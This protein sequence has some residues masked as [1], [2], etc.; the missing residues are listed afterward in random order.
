MSN[1]KQIQKHHTS[2]KGP[3][4]VAILISFAAVSVLYFNFQMT[5][6]GADPTSVTATSGKVKTS[7]P[8][9]E[10]PRIAKRTADT[11]PRDVA[12]ATSDEIGNTSDG[13]VLKGRMAL[14]L[15]LLLLERGCNHFKHITHY[16]ATFFKQEELDGDL[17]EGQIIEMKVRHQPFS[18]YMKWL[19]GDK[20]QEVLFVDGHY[21][22]KM[23]VK[24]GGLKGRFL[25]ALKLDPTGS[26][27][28]R[29][30]RYPVTKAGLLQLARTIVSYREH[31]LKMPNGV[32]CQMVDNQKFSDRDT[33]YFLIEYAARENSKTYRKSEIYVDKELSMPV[34]V[35][36]YSWPEEGSELVGEK[37]DEK[38]LIEFYSFTN[39]N[40]ERQL[41]DI[42]F[43]RM[44]KAYRLRR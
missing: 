5:P 14:L 35:R 42:D 2:C 13:Y 34:C 17:G 10:R 39:L 40:F 4:F 44:N 29:A 26:M 21:D 12:K 22:G 6:V 33:Y 15:N 31:D 19:S 7:I 37:L 36:N 41:A 32:S 20:G 9:P 18:T 24:A 8:M 28:M 38:T 25:P 23:I 30:A 3:N 11:Q 43:D 27:A 1:R 16:T